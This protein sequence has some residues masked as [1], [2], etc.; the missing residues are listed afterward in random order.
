MVVQLVTPKRKKISLYSDLHK[1]LTQNP[2]NN[3]LA[4]K[5]DEESVKESL[6]NLILTDKGERLMQPNVGGNVRSLLFDNITPATIKLAE[7]QIRSTIDDY[8]PRAE[9]IDV[10]VKSAAD[11]NRIEI[12]IRFFLTNIEQ[13]ISVNI[14]LERIR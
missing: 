8:E 9:I 3:D 13:P 2:L 1:D 4:L 7:E 6:K 11:E 14:F 5:R 12:T 10:E